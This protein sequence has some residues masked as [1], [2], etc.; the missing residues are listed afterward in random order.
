LKRKPGKEYFVVDLI[1]PGHYVTLT[2]VE[3]DLPGLPYSFI[4][5]SV[6]K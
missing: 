2:L 4:E 5:E 1:S 3:A 6:G